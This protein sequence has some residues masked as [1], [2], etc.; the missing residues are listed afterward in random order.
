MAGAYGPFKRYMLTGS[1][2][3]GLAIGGDRLFEP[4]RPALPRPEQSERMAEF[5]LGHGPFE[6]HALTG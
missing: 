6:R 4:R 1:F 5:H 2:L 3:Q